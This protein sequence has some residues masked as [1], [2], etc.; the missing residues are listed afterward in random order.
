MNKLIAALNAVVGLLALVYYALESWIPGDYWGMLSWAML[1]MCVVAFA[2][3]CVGKSDRESQAAA[4][5]VMTTAFVVYHT[6]AG[7]FDA[8][9]WDLSCAAFGVQFGLGGLKALKSS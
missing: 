7:S 3:L 6:L 2:L 8:L 1:V 9:T 5:T 4:L